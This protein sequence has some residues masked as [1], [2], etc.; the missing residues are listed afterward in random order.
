MT[1]F[2]L[3]SKGFDIVWL[4]VDR[5]TKSAHFLAIKTS[6]TLEKLAELY[7]D[8]VVRLHGVLITILSDQDT[9][10]V[11]HFWRILHKALG[12]KLAFNMAFHPQMM[13]NL[14]G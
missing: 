8:Q 11:A 12:T 2:P 14:R 7:I 9:W 3:T 10:F 4:V 6:M 5:L 1:R 13:G